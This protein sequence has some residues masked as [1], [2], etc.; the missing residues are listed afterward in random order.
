MTID[1]QAITLTS[2]EFQKLSLLSSEQSRI[3][4]GDQLMNSSYTD[5]RIVS[6]RTLD[7][8]IK[9]L[10]KKMAVIGNEDWIQPS[11]GVGYKLV[12]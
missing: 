9:K 3:F 10:R 12:V 1:Q 11:Y 8:H 7:S 4:S 5:H 2:A 6:V